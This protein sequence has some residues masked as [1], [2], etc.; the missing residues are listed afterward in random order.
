MPS[1]LLSTSRPFSPLQGVL[2]LMTPMPVFHSYA[3]PLVSGQIFILAKIEGPF[4]L[5]DPLRPRRVLSYKS[6]LFVEELFGGGG[7]LPLVI[8]MLVFSPPLGSSLPERPLPSA[9]PTT[10]SRSPG[11]LNLPIASKPMRR[12]TVSQLESREA[13][14]I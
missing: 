7:V 9:S 14:H 2:L 12:T 3:V 13:E 5:Y 1:S 4:Y 11:R 8:P 6:N 10:R